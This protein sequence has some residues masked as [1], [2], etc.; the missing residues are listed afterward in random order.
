MLWVITGG[1]AMAG[2]EDILFENFTGDASTRW[3]YVQDGVMG[4]VSQGQARLEDGTLTLVGTVSTANNGGFI[5]VRQ[6]NFPAWPAT[7]RGLRL[8]VQGNG[9]NYYVFLRTPELA[10]V[11]Y[12]YRAEFSTGPDWAEVDLPFARFAASNDR[13]PQSFTPDQVSSIGIVAYGRDH[14]ADI[15]IRSIS[16]Y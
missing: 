4:G 1:A 5:Q 12:S 11:F 13:I 14:E 10:R 16:L 7:A 6:R 3:A 9:E 15:R 2:P 8:S